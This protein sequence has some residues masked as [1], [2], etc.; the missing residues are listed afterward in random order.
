M[1]YDLPKIEAYQ[2]EKAHKEKLYRIERDRLKPRSFIFTNYPKTNYYGLNV[3]DAKEY[4]Y[5]DFVARF[6]RL[7][8]RNVL[9]S[10][11]YNNID[12]SILNISSNLDKPLSSFVA[13]GFNIYQKE[14]KLLD[15]SFDEEKELLLSSDEYIKY[16]QDFFLYLFE[17][18]QISLKHGLVVFDDKRVYQKGEY[19]QERGRYFSLDGKGLNST[20]KN[21]YALNLLS[22]KKDLFNSLKN[23]NISDIQKELILEKLCY[24]QGVSINFATTNDAY[25]NLKLEKPE[26]ICGISF[27]VLNP[28]YVDVKPFISSS[29]YNEIQEELFNSK[30]RLLFTGTYAINPVISSYIPIFISEIF[31]DAIH[32]G[33]PSVNEVDENM[34]YVYDVEYNPIF[35][36]VND[37]CILVNSGRFN[38]LTV[39]EAKSEVKEC[40]IEKY[41]ASVYNEILLDEIN[42]SSPLK[43]GIPIPLHNDQTPSKT[44]VVYSL[45]H[46]VK[47]E[48]GD[49][50]DKSLV[51]D[52]LSDEF[53]NYLL[54]NAIRLK[55]ETGI[56]N[57]TEK[58]ALDEIS[59]FNKIDVAAF[60]QSNYS[61]DI[62]W[63][64]IFNHLWSK[65]YV[66]GFDAPIKDVLI[67]KPILDKDLHYMNRDNNNLVSISSVI[68]KYGSTILRLYYAIGGI[69]EEAYTYDENEMDGIGELVNKIIKMFYYPID[70]L[71]SELDYSFNNLV[72]DS[73][74]HAKKYDYRSYVEDITSFVNRVH[75]VKHISRNQARGFL[76]ILSVLTPSL[77][78]QIKEDVLNLKEP[79][80]YYSWPE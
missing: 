4:V 55:G 61:K 52:F 67:F 30:D 74:K 47:L 5:I 49:L 33:I 80:C 23:L 21:Y 39:D 66:S 36:F 54:P 24:S 42:I 51:K 19:Y 58:E 9:F 79:L 26:Y 59:L 34:T 2:I 6:E 62:L 35:D 37:D 64:L 12:S 72:S 11:G 18:K 14:L 40:L 44:P 45:K 60:S 57:F 76:V 63:N 7:L 16:V 48:D 46:D 70:D 68:N 20:I 31:T 8:G 43:F 32:I 27:I 28:N 77:A 22:I 75:E 65:Y 73:K 3:S 29:E 50:A 10:L 53:S 78:E 15:I 38:G 41:H 56:L 13:G 69:D 25:I 17:K 1:I 71:C